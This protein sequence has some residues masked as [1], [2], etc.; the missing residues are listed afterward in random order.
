MIPLW[1]KPEWQEFKPYI[2]AGRLNVATGVKINAN[3]N[4][5]LE[6]ENWM[7]PAGQDE[8]LRQAWA[9]Y[10]NCKSDEVLLTRGADEGIDVLAR[11]ALGSGR[12]C[13]IQPPTYGMYEV[14]AK[15][16]LGTDIKSC[17]LTEN[18]QPDWEKLS[19]IKAPGILFLCRPN[20][21]TGD[22]VPKQD[23]IS[24][25]KKLPSNILLVVDEAYMDYSEM[26]SEE[27]ISGELMSS[28]QSMI[29]EVS[30]FENLVVL[31]TL[32]KAFGLA[33]LRCGA[34]IA[35]ASTCRWLSGLLA[36]YPLPTPS[37]EQAKKALNKDNVKQVRQAVMA[38]NSQRKRMI[39][40]FRRSALFLDIIDAPVNYICTK[41]CDAELLMDKMAANGIAPRRLGNYIRW[42]VGLEHE[43][44]KLE[45]VM[46]A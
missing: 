44:D 28:D 22:D 24:G 31:R 8:N 20:N 32:S 30:R 23:I 46:S 2:S 6:G 12:V 25:L 45:K 7:Y 40:L 39:D 15:L 36:P 3:E 9:E 5:Y 33:G 27:I 38:M 34:L 35:K 13:Y 19:E 21:P 18:R 43:I 41:P 10:L 1:A 14:S 16:Q 29:S 26:L 11:A 4:P 42:T 17:P 37:I